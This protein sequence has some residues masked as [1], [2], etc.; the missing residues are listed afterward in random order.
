MINPIPQLKGLDTQHNTGLSKGSE[1]TA[2][3]VLLIRMQYKCPEC[4]MGL[5]VTPCF[6]VYHTEQ[7]FSAPSDNELETQST[8]TSKFW[9]CYY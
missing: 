4:N 8:H 6:K 5:C 2:M 7:H 9:H 3:C 1:F